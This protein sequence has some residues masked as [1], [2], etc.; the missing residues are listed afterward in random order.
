M[1]RLRARLLFD[2]LHLSFF[3]PI[4]PPPSPG[5]PIEAYDTPGN[6]SADVI[7]ALIDEIGIS[8]LRPS[9]HLSDHPAMQKGSDI[10]SEAESVSD[11]NLTLESATPNGADLPLFDE[12]FTTPG[13]VPAT[14]H[15]Q[16]LILG[17]VFEVRPSSI[18]STITPPQSS[19]RARKSHPPNLDLPRLPVPQRWSSIR[20]AKSPIL[21]PA[22]VQRA[23]LSV[24][25]SHSIKDIIAKY[26]PSALKAE[27]NLRDK[28]IL[29][30]RSSPSPSLA[31][32]NRSASVN[33]EKTLPIVAES[34]PPI[35][36]SPTIS[37]SPGGRR[38]HRSTMPSPVPQRTS[39]SPG[40]LVHTIPQRSTSRAESRPSHEGSI[41][42]SLLSSD[43]SHTTR[44]FKQQITMG[45]ALLDKL[46][47]E[48]PS[49]PSTRAGS[50]KRVSF[51]IASPDLVARLEV[52][53]L[54]ASEHVSTSGIDE[55]EVLLAEY[56][57]SPHLNRIFHAP[58][59]QGTSL[60][61]SVSDIGPPAGHPVLFILGLGCV[62]YMTALFDHI[63]AA[64]NL[65]LICIDRWGYGKTDSIPDDER[66]PLA[67]A[68]VVQQILPQMGIE[69]F[70][71]IVHSAGTP[72][73]LA[74]LARM[75][76]RVKGT[77]HLLAPWTNTEMNGGER[78]S[79]PDAAAY[80]RV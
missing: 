66:L 60:S 29:E 13:S 21:S 74:L 44:S 56:L 48:S 49:A 58:Q 7:D 32:K 51:A 28:A 69:D 37:L 10:E 5:R 34:V 42:S 50:I 9:E 43:S 75:G 27:S 71:L 39:S 26:S 77:V 41:S 64:Y 46:E 6:I 38:R 36:C 35:S 57:R 47:H 8:S 70:G 12:R 73:A 17:P 79:L 45:Q 25:S 76:N 1:S 68:S 78:W 62:R 19:R 16:T 31:P 11:L 24:S 55:P 67:W 22:D 23:A 4:K 15:S 52:T 3:S 2:I 33:L 40:V 53:R 59:P 63:A 80:V 54:G 18:P 72:F 20:P 61:V 65:R 30:L 14:Q